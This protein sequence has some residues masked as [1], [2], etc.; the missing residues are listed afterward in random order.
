MSDEYISPFLIPPWRQTQRD[1][2]GRLTYSLPVEEEKEEA[3]N[4]HTQ[5]VRQL[6]HDPRNILVYT[7]GSEHKVHGIRRAGAG[8]VV[9]QQGRETAVRSLG[10]GS[11]ATSFDAELA[12]LLAGTRNAVNA[13]NLNVDVTHIYIFTDNSAVITTALDPKPTAGQLLAHN[14]CQT[15]HS[16]LD[17]NASRQV[18]LKWVPSHIGIEGNARADHLAKA[19]AALASSLPVAKTRTFARRVAKER[20]DRAWVREWKDAPRNGHYAIANRFPPS[21][22]PTPRFL[23]LGDK[24]EVF[25]RLT[26][27]RTGHGYTGEF[28][29]RFVPNESSDCPCGEPLQTRKHI[30]RDCAR[31]EAHSAPEKDWRPL[32]LSSRSLAHSPRLA[33][34]ESP[35]VHL[36]SKTSRVMMTMTMKKHNEREQKWTGLAVPEM[37]LADDEPLTTHITPH[38]HP[39]VD[40]GLDNN[41][42]TNPRTSPPGALSFSPFFSIY[43]SHCCPDT[44]FVHPPL[45]PPSITTLH[46][47]R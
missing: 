1:F 41:V 42:Y 7:D 28:Y 12:G 22:R 5:L 23:M 10:L 13:C 36:S 17:G 39:S 35:H 3:K 38:R 6:S 11:Q 32:L 31:Y 45:T 14:F 18:T 33:G 16:F 21:T 30:I 9:Y 15:V 26:Q 46:H 43:C 29:R 4:R 40:A 37:T 24:R 8:F 27:C 44:P 19:G 20:L 47:T 25:G 34:H 2:G